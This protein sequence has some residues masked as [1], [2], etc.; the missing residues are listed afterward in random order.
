MLR[1]ILALPVGIAVAIAIVG[2]LE[3][4]SHQFFDVADSVD[5]HDETAARAFIA[6]LPLAAILMIGAAWMIGAF[7]GSLVAGKLGTLK[8]Q[9]CASTVT[10]LILAGA[11]TNLLLIPHPVWFSITAPI[12]VILA[13]IAAWQ[14]LKRS[15][16]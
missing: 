15:A 13:G 14:L 4:L 3:W 16:T 11:I 12:G 6:S 8:P 7:T 1:N 10:G 9:I 2:G 5:M